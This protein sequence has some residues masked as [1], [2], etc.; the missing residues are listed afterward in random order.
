MFPK[1]GHG[2]K[3]PAQD[4]PTYIKCM[5]GSLSSWSSGTSEAKRTFTLQAGALSIG[6]PLRKR[7]SGF[8]ETLIT[9]NV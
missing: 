6:V 3:T 2:L 4:S 7:T 9:V 5:I 8:T 1:C